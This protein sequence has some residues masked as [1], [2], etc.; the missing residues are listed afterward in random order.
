MTDAERI[1]REVARLDKEIAEIKD[2]QRRLRGD[3]QTTCLE[4]NS[5]SSEIRWIR[6]TLTN[7]AAKKITGFNIVVTILL[8]LIG[9]GTLFGQIQ[10]NQI[11]KEMVRIAQGSIHP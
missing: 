11:Q 4:N 10:N 9:I 5:M 6:E 3:I 2:E 7:M 8:V 1:E